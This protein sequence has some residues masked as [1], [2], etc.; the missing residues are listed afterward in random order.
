M[1]GTIEQG[2]ELRVTRLIKAPRDRIFVAWITPDDLLKW[3]GPEEC[4]V[5]SA[6]VHPRVGGEYQLR[7]QTENYGEISL[8]GIF[9]EL[10]QPDKLVY[11][12]NMSGHPKLEFGESLVTVEFLDRSGSTE[13][14]ITHDGL[15]NEEVKQDHDQGWNGCLDKL[16]KHLT[17]SSQTQ[18]CAVPVGE[19]SW[20]EL[21]T[22]D[23]TDAARFYTQLFGWQTADFPGGE[24]KYTLFRK[25]G[26]EVGGLM[27]R[28]REE[29]PPHWLGYITVA[30]VDATAKQAGELGGQVIMPPFDVPSVGRIAVL[31]DPQGAVFGIFQPL[32]TT[33]TRMRNQIVWCDIP[34]KDLD[35]AIR[36]YSAVLGA[37]IKKE[38]HGGMTF[39]VLPHLEDGVSG[40]LS[41]GG[42]GNE[43]SQ[44]GTLI[45]LNCEGRLDEAVAAVEPNDGKVLQGR[46]QIGPYG[47]RAVVL[48]SE[49]NRIALHSM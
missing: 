14:Q 34:V 4:R 42:E 44:R 7:L 33:P 38:Q 31:H 22:S 28:P 20:N 37:P 2:L 3:F 32:E 49:G 26:K 5:L 18:P 10:K 8:H 25:D 9:R 36:F 27:K 39:A 13:V 40:C 48:D 24:V 46:H 45:Y 11:T 30:N 23:E 47:F 6:R 19:F 15:P 21:L 1:R 16:E 41:P 35:R 43:P 17:E 29:V 12:W